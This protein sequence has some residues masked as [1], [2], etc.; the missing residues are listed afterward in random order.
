MAG[1]AGDQPG[2]AG[3]D[4]VPGQGPGRLVAVERGRSARPRA[5]PA[6]ARQVRRTSTRGDQADQ[7]HVERRWPRPTKSDDPAGRATWLVGPAE[8]RRRAAGGATAA[9][10][11]EQKP[12]GVAADAAVGQTGG[13]ETGKGRPGR[14]GPRVRPA[15][16]RRR[17]VW[18]PR[19]AAPAVSRRPGAGRGGCR[20][21][22]GDR[23]GGSAGRGGGP[24]RPGPGGARRRCRSSAR[25]RGPAR[26]RSCSPDH[27]RRLRVPRGLAVAASGQVDDLA[28]RALGEGD[29]GRQQ[30]RVGGEG[31]AGV[32]EAAGHRVGRQQVEGA[33]VEDQDARDRSRRRWPGPTRCWPGSRPG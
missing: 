23:S 4:Q 28:S 1:V 32:G 29:D 12:P 3:G 18:C 11:G 7:E 5:T 13:Q 22:C 30:L 33:A 21:G 6:S 17:A 27:R 20:P 8:R 24:A 10:S 25:R 15:S 14:R 9:R 16:L 26:R 2:V 19:P 31:G